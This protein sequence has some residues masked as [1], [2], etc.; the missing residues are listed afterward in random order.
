MHLNFEQWQF[1]RYILIYYF[2]CYFY[3]VVNSSQLVFV[4]VLSP[5]QSVIF[6]VGRE[7]IKVAGVLRICLRKKW[8]GVGMEI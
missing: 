6:H 1:N 3:T 4:L 2:T 7:M 8:G 5:G